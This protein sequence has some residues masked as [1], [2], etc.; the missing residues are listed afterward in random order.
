MALAKVVGS[1]NRLDPSLI[2]L[3]SAE[4]R[5]EMRFFYRAAS[6]WWQ[7]LQWYN[8]LCVVADDLRPTIAEK[9]EVISAGLDASCLKCI[10]EICPDAHNLFMNMRTSS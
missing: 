6:P 8:L 4:S 10:G 5:Q 9:G 3:A 1:G 7:A 2:P